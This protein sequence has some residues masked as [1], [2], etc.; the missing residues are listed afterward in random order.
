METKKPD[1][2]V[3]LSASATKDKHQR[4]ALMQ[5]IVLSLLFVLLVIGTF[6]YLESKERPDSDPGRG[7]SGNATLDFMSPQ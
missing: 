6:V 5:W 7:H 3:Q 2:N 4:R 1:K